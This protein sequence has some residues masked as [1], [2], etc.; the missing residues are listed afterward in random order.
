MKVCKKIFIRHAGPPLCRGVGLHMKKSYHVKETLALDLQH[1][2]SH[3][4]SV[5]YLP[6]KMDLDALQFAFNILI[7]I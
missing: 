2:N 5:I 7:Q 3:Y 1:S 4:T 6:K